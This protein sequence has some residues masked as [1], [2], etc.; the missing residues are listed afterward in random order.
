MRLRRL[1]DFPSLILAVAFAAQLDDVA[2][3]KLRSS[4]ASTWTG[5]YTPSESGISTLARPRQICGFCFVRM[6]LDKADSS[7]IYLDEFPQ[8]LSY[9]DDLNARVSTKETSAMSILSSH[10]GDAALYKMIEGAQFITKTKDFAAKLEGK[11]MQHWVATAKDPDDVFR[12]ME[13][14]KIE[15]DLLRNTKFNVWAKYVDDFNARYPETATTMVPTL[16][17][18]RYDGRLLFSMAAAGMKVETTKTP[19]PSYRN[20]WFTFLTAKPECSIFFLRRFDKEDV[21]WVIRAAKAED[22]TRDV[23]TKL[24]SAQLKIWWND[25]KSVDDVTNLLMLDGRAVT[26]TNNPL[27]STCV[28]YMNIFITENPVKVTKLLSSL[29]TQFKDR[30]LNQI[31]QLASKFPSMEAAA[32]KTQIE[33]M[34]GYLANNESPAKVFKLLALD[35]V[36]DTILSNPLFTRWKDYVEDFN[37]NTLVNTNH[38]SPRSFGIINGVVSIE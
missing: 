18:H 1:I 38:G 33:K 32:T 7:L 17:L 36:G 34:L 26:F 30:P 19:P 23:V 10:L 35:D 22:A 3:S 8:W 20:N 24:E 28:S 5:V 29:E 16:R 12:L 11:L 4:V 13:L 14:D 2:G 15:R 9:V 6:R 25:G 31:L 37:K 27:V 21:A